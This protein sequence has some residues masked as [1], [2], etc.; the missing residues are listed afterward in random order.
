[1]WCRK[2]LHLVFKIPGRF[3]KYLISFVISY[4][5]TN[6]L[7]ILVSY[8]KLKLL[9]AK[10]KP[11]KYM[12]I[13]SGLL[14]FVTLASNA[15]VITV[16]GNSFDDKAS[17]TVDIAA[18]MEWRD[19]QLTDGRSFCSVA[20]DTGSSVPAACSS[21]DNMDLISDAEGWQYATRAQVAQLLT[22]W[23]GVPVDPAGYTGVDPALSTQF[24]DVFAGGASDSR[25]DFLSDYADYPAQAEGIYVYAGGS[26]VSTYYFNGN[27][28]YSCC[29][30]GSLLV[31]A[32]PDASAAVPEPMSPALIALGLAG[33]VFMRRPRVRSK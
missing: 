15:A 17:S 22:D 26:Y 30:Q 16:S 31:R 21:F 13:L 5:H 18:K 28:N 33:L 12:K 24:L 2:N 10:M 1:M 4:W 14:M 29:G 9:G 11:V 19:I 6:C 32:V 20:K 3:F 27:I 7:S 8:N 25:P 23:M